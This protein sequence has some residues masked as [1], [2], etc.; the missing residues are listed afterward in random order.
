M[1][2]RKLSLGEVVSRAASIAPGYTLTAT[3]YTNA[4]TRMPWACPKGHTF[5]MGWSRFNGGCRC[6]QCSP[7]AK[8]SQEEVA[9]T[10][11][12]DGYVLVGIYENYATPMETQCPEGHPFRVTLGNFVKG[13]RCP[14]CHGVPRRTI[15]SVRDYVESQG[16]KLLSTKYERSD[17]KLEIECPEGHQ[18]RMSWET[19][20]GG[21]RCRHCRGGVRLTFE[22]VVE[23]VRATGST[24]HPCV[25]GNAK[26]KLPLTCPTGHYFEMNLNNLNSGERCPECVSVN[27]S[28]A[29]REV[30]EWLTTHGIPFER[31]HR[32]PCLPSLRSTGET[33]L[34]FFLPTLQAAIECNGEQHYRRVPYFHKTVDA[35]AKQIDRDN[36]VRYYCKQAGIRLLEIPYWTDTT[37][38]LQACLSVYVE[39]V[40]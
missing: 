22:Q 35:F 21:T 30:T 24:L 6:P 40:G 13:H 9:A 15:E 37:A 1:K 26:T 17:A 33:A 28:K 14:H 5:Q 2:G 12:Q 39:K 34:D 8:K 31:Q 36:Y 23:A 27:Y 19:F 11:I 29:E 20:L 4:V 18:F 25:Y 38:A 7:Q 3:S 32:I 10:L 16:H